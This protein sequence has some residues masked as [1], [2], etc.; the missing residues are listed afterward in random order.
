MRNSA[1]LQRRKIS[2][3]SRS[4]QRSIQLCSPHLLSS[5]RAIHFLSG[6]NIER[7]AKSKLLSALDAYKGRDYEKERQKK[8]AKAAE[9][10]K[11]AKKKQQEEDDEVQKC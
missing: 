6:R 11:A 1:F 2:I 9:K 5:K 8:L 10:R 7:M 3:S 4:L